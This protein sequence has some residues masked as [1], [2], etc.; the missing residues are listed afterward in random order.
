MTLQVGSHWNR[1]VGWVD[2][3][4]APKGQTKSSGRGGTSGKYYMAKQHAQSM[5]G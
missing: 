2:Q 1:G 4:H 3:L 5:V